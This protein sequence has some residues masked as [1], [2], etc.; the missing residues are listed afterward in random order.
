MN[1]Q[2]RCVIAALPTAE[3]RTMHTLLRVGVPR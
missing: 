2:H 1:D 3:L